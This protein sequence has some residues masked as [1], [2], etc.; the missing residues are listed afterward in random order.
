[1]KLSLEETIISIK[2]LHKEIKKCENIIHLNELSLSFSKLN[3]K[4]DTQLKNE[5]FMN[6]HIKNII[7]IF[8]ML[9]MNFENCVNIHKY[10][11][12]HKNLN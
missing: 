4:F 9:K 5:R 11:L 6:K 2:N 7:K 1:M 12:I 8:D 10:I 3:E